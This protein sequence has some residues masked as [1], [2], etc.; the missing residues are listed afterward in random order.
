MDLKLL[1]VIKHGGM[2]Y[3]PGD[4]IRG[5]K[6][7]DGEYLISLGVAEDVTAANDE[8]EMKAMKLAEKLAA[9]QKSKEE[10]E[11][12][13]AEEKAKAEATANEEAEKKKGK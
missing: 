5:I 6:K 3:R 8:V 9:E 12:L 13:T 4:E 11:R 2:W 7:E 1:G 10:A